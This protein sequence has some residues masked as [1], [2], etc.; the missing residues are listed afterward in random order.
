MK[1]DNRILSSYL[2]AMQERVLVMD[3]AMGTNLAT[4]NLTSRHFGGEQFNGCNDYLSLTYPQAV[5]K[6]HRA[7]LDKGVDVIESN[8]FRSNR[9]TLA[10]FG[11]Q[12]QTGA[13]NLAAARLARRLADAY[14]RDG[15]PRFVA[16]AMGPTGKLLSL[17]SPDEE[18]LDFDTAS[19]IFREQATYLIEGGAD[20]MLLETQQDILEVK[21]AI[22][23]IHKAFAECG[24]VLPIQAQVTLDTN[25][26]MLLGTD[27]QAVLTILEGHAA[28]T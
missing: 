24:K 4:Q 3:G 13:I 7:F 11:L 12:E 17:R 15:R 16:G 26:R 1:I 6:V 20:F 2:A 10:E 23:G 28:L 27:I 18:P 8:T 9:Q 19:D 14:A 5:E 22:V 25:G 21:A